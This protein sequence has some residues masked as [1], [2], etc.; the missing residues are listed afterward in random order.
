[1]DNALDVVL[2]MF[3]TVPIYLSVSYPKLIKAYYGFVE[4]IFRN[5]KKTVFA[6]ET[7]VVMKIMAEIHKGLHTSDATL[8]SLFANT[9]D[10]IATYYFTNTGKGNV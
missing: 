3:L 5:H 2:Q 4:I 7:I 1:M 6:L 10:H 9:I 8:S